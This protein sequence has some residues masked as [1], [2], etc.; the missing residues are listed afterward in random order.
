MKESMLENKS[1]MLHYSIYGAILLGAFWVF[2]YLLGILSND[3]AVLNFIN[4]FLSIGTP[5]I[6]FIYLLRY[7]SRYVDNKMS[8][9]HGIQFSILMFFFA[10]ILEAVI[11]F[12]HVNWI[13]QAFI[14]NLY[15]SLVDIARSLNLSETITAQLAEQPLPTSFSY[16]V[17]NVIMA[18]VFIG[19]IL[20]LLIVPIVRRLKPNNIA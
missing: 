8:L 14:S 19:L 5:I 20:S 7:N 1:Q 17:S 16:V 2:K 6:L 10:S 11:V 12:I 9:G 4:S 3:F 13:D 18:D 15:S